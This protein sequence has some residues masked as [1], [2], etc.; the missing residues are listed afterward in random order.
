MSAE[1]I[2]DI[3]ITALCAYYFYL[4]QPPCRYAAGVQAGVD[5]GSDCDSGLTST[6]GGTIP[7]NLVDNTSV[8]APVDPVVQDE[9]TE[10]LHDQPSSSNTLP[11]PNTTVPINAVNAGEI[12]FTEA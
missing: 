10:S 9:P 12:E 5:D 11:T 2:Q 6:A 4:Q 8:D 3:V 1:C 7:G